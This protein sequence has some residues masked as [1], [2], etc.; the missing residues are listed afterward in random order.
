MS[1]CE[2]SLHM[3]VEIQRI[4]CFC[5]L[6]KHVRWC[7]AL[8]DDDCCIHSTTSTG[9]YRNLGCNPLRAAGPS[10]P[11][12]PLCWGL[13]SSLMTNAE[14]DRLHAAADALALHSGATC[15]LLSLTGNILSISNTLEAIYN[16]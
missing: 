4:V 12:S 15:H 1:P 9:F 16:A 10:C 8:R 14:L 2:C 3:C 11:V 6:C 13:S 7:S 5:V